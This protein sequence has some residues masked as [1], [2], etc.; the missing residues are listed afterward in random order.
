MPYV[1]E[2]TSSQSSPM[3]SSEPPPTTSATA[4]TPLAE[5]EAKEREP[6]PIVSVDD[7]MEGS[8]HMQ[9]MEEY[10]EFAKAFKEHRIKLGYNQ[11]DVS[12]QIG[13]R[14]GYV[15]SEGDVVQFESQNM[16]VS[17]VQKLRPMF[18]VW[19][20]D[21]AK[22]AGNTEEQIV[23]I[24]TSRK[25]MRRPRRSLHPI[26]RELLEA[27]F[28]LKPKPTQS[29]MGMLAS[30][31]G[32][33]KDFIQIWFCN[34]RQKEKRTGRGVSSASPPLLADVSLTIN[35]PSNDITL[36]VPTGSEE[37]ILPSTVDIYITQSSAPS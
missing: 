12:Q 1:S 20:S 6:S 27:N 21:T 30:A 36:E 17:D 26:A 15:I 28:C 25:S 10:Q 2:E 37:A 24:A 9:E 5:A 11:A 33:D 4:I 8:S 34:R 19:V 7:P 35:S 31:L 14:Y 23:G 13:L 3:Q 29:E 18:E 32:V 16:E 22:A